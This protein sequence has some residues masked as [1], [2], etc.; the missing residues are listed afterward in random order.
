MY[1]NLPVSMP[2]TRNSRRNGTAI[3]RFLRKNF[4]SSEPTHC[5]QLSHFLIMS[6]H[7][8]VLFDETLAGYVQKY[9]EAY[10][11]PIARAR[12]LKDCREDITKSPLHEERDIELPQHL[13]WVSFI[14]LND[15]SV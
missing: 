3:C 4:L 2:F 6:A 15:K 5:N 9:M 14:S 1:R 12:I 11:N 10:G 8:S 13:Y 7:W